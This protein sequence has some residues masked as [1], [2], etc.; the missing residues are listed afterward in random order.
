MPKNP[1]HDLPNKNTLYLARTGGGKSQAVKQNP[2]IPGPNQGARV[3]LLDPGHD[4]ARPCT[5][6]F[7]DRGEFARVLARAHQSGRGYRLAYD[8]ERSVA[9]FEWFCQ[10]VLAVLDGRWQTYVIVEELA[11]VC[12]PGGGEAPPAHNQL[13]SEGRKFGLVFH[14]TSQ[15]PQEIS[16][17]DYENCST[18]WVG[19]QKAGSARL[20]ERELGVPAEQL[21]RLEPLQ[22]YV[23]R[24]EKPDPELVQL[25]Y[26]K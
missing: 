12:P 20:F 23:A 10:C 15:R 2:E 1:R 25:T 5:H 17:T 14:G 18:W 3:I 22:F 11:R 16:K 21:R 7:S 9:I 4:H 24:E 19:P 6:Y 13:I 8:G 26:R